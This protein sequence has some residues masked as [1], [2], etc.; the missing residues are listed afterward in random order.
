MRDKQKMLGLAGLIAALAGCAGGDGR[1]PSLALR[2]FE[3]GVAAPEPVSEPAPIRSP[4]QQ[5]AVTA[6]AARA[7]SAHGAFLSQQ[8]ATEP[9]ARAAR[10]LSVETNARARALV[11][12]AVLSSRRSATAAVL[13]DIDAIAAEAATSLAEDPALATT[14]TR[15]AAMV[16]SEDAAL[17]RLWELM[18][19]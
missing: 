9:L 14:Q 2:P 19:S 11:A 6:L 12:M 4:E 18:G 17:A 8:T 7:D 3:T 10:G 5:A 15:I 1:Y 13:A 16:A